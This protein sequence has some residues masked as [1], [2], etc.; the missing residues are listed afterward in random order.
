MGQ[1]G[2]IVHTIFTVKHRVKFTASGERRFWKK[3]YLSQT[4]VDGSIGVLELSKKLI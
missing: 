1:L 4:E 2:Q 3:I